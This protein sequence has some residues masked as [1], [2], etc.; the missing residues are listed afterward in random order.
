LEDLGFV[1]E[2]LNAL[3]S[4]VRDPT[5]D[6]ETK[7]AIAGDLGDL[8]DSKEIRNMLT[9][10]LY[11]TAESAYVRVASAHS[12]TRLGAGQKAEPVLMELARSKNPEVR[13]MVAAVLGEL[14]RTGQAEELF[15]DLVRDANVE[16]GERVF[17]TGLLV[18]NGGAETADTL[19]TIAQDSGTDARVRSEAYNSL[20]KIIG[21]PLG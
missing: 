17:V 7:S 19:L 13:R 2:A 6:D 1:N 9:E 15:L 21:N 12:L 4:L 10:W 5:I 16:I 20:K 11:S 14:G 8:S 18:E 3:L